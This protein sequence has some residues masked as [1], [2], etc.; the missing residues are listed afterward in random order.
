MIL[1]VFS[2]SSFVSLGSLLGAAAPPLVNV[3][4]WHWI[5]FIALV[6][7]L[8]LTD[9]IFFHNKSK[10][11]TLREAAIATSVWVMIALAFNVFLWWAAGGEAATVFFTGYLVEWSLSMDNVF[12]F[13]VIFNYFKVPMKYQYRVLFWGILGAVVMRLSFILIGA[14]VLEHF[15][16]VTYILGA[17]L[18]YTGYKLAT[19]D[20]E[21]DPE[22]GWALRISRKLFPVSKE[23]SGE[24]FFVREAGKLMITPLFLVLIV[25]QTT[26][27]AFSFDSV[28]AIFGFT[29]DPFI[30]FS[31]NVFAI[32]GLRALYF[33]LAGV[34]GMFRYLNYGLSAILIF[35]GFKMILHPLHDP[36]QWLLNLWAP[37][38]WVQKWV[39]NPPAWAS[40][41]VVVSMLTIA[42]VASLVH[43]RID[44]GENKH[45]KPIAELPQ[46]PVASGAQKDV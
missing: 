19:G 17:F 34:M 11:P 26:D 9:L 23:Y 44:G 36:P 7:A 8:L 20:E 4:F 25:I 40:L 37:P 1:D 6:T 18:I 21:A 5:A 41:L 16:W 24:K 32:L 39:G 3:T 45:G 14:V 38:L 10:E 31:S 22:H 12:V 42:I 46:D 28:P 29:D 33:L 43:N 15:A 30:I 13:A 27:F 35:I 2:G